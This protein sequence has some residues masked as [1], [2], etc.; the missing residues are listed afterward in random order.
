M[1]NKAPDDTRRDFLSNTG[2]LALAAGAVTAA[3][4]MT[5]PDDAQAEAPRAK[6]GKKIIGG[7]PSRAYSRA[8]RLDRTV[9]VSGVVGADRKG[10]IQSDFEMQAMQT[11]LNLKE[12][13]ERSGSR[14]QNVLKCTCFLKEVG[15]FSTFNKIY[16]KFFKEDPPARST[17]VVK[18]L[19]VPNAKLE[20]DCVCYV[21]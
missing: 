14:I 4:H 10:V 21:N 1:S 5:V 9:Y 19:V 6:K 18:D 16:V 11:L 2:K 17:V 13:V 3:V 20:V 7:S 15:N 12:S 8:V